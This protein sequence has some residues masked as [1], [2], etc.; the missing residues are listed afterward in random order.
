[1]KALHY[2]IIVLILAVSIFL[3]SEPM[4]AQTSPG[5]TDAPTTDIRDRY[6]PTTWN[7]S[8]MRFI[9]D[10]DSSYNRYTPKMLGQTLEE[11]GC[12]LGVVLNQEG[13]DLV[14]GDVCV[15]D[16]TRVV[17]CDTV[18]NKPGRI[19]D[20]LSGR[21]GWYSMLYV[22]AD[23]TASDDSLVITGLDEDGAAQSETLVIT[24][25]ANSYTLSA[26]KWSKVLTVSD[27]QS[28]SGWDSYDVCAT[29][30]GAI[31]ASDGASD[32]F[33]GVVAGYFDTDGD[34]QDSIPDNNIGFVVTHGVIEAF[35]D[36]ASTPLYNG[37]MLQMAAGGDAVAFADTT[38]SFRVIARA[39]EFLNA[40]NS[41]IP[42]FVNP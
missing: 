33:A 25:G 13:S 23:G 28:S 6:I 22:V 38:H 41:L 15:W 16:S 11:Q 2:L 10:R 3:V 24:D 17:V 35:C 7:K 31:R 21:G 40:D 32:N 9:D 8:L 30:Y 29:M 42:I 26:N 4:V 39:L 36:G 1:V 12:V 27:A 34:W 37:S 20:D 5:W 18:K 14:R 19:E